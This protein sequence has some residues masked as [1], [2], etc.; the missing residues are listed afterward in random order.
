MVKLLSTRFVPVALGNHQPWSPEDVKFYSAA[1]GGGG[2]NRWHVITAGG[3]MLAQPAYEMGLD[4]LKSALRDFKAEENPEIPTLSKESLKSTVKPPEGGLV[5]YVTWKVV[6][7]FDKP[8]S[9]DEA[10]SQKSLGVDRLWL[11]KVE[12]L[13]LAKGEFPESMKNRIA[14]CLSFGGQKK[15]EMSFSKGRLSGSV[16]SETKDDNN[17]YQADILGFIEAKDGKVTRFDVVAKGPYWWRGKNKNPYGGSEPYFWDYGTSLSIVPNDRKVTLAMAF[18]LADPNDGLAQ[19][20][21]A[22]FMSRSGK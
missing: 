15:A 4:Q 22:W 9:K 12:A 3:K 21:P 13:A 8:K 11:P 6:D 20:P 17:G 10:M 5:L 1:G 2:T 19:V 16:H 18:T 14:S 7:G